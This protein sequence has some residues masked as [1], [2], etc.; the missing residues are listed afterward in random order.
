MLIHCIRLMVMAFNTIGF[1]FVF[2]F[3]ASVAVKQFRFVQELN[4]VR[5][6]FYNRAVE[7]VFSVKC[8]ALELSVN[9]DSMPFA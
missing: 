4:A 1:Q 2:H 7:T 5:F 8:S 9:Q 6:N 3:G